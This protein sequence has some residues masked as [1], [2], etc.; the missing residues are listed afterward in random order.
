MCLY[1]KPSS[2]SSTAPE[3]C[4]DLASESPAV[5]S[6]E[7]PHQTVCEIIIGII[8][9]KLL[10]DLSLLAVHWVASLVKLMQIEEMTNRHLKIPMKLMKT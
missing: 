1:P 10:A 7:F 8:H 3:D 2:S 6:I 9:S 4:L 5:E